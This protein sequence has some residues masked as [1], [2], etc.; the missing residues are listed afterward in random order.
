M[1]K[2]ILILVLLLLTG[3]GAI[4]TTPTILTPNEFPPPPPMTPIVE[5]PQVTATA[6]IEPRMQPILPSDLQEAETFFLIVKT[7]MAAGDDTG[8]AKRVKYPLQVNLNGQQIFIHNEAEFV[9]QYETIFDAKF[10]QVLSDIDESTLTLLSNGVQVGNG[11][12]WFNY[13]CVD[14]E[15]SDA[16]FLITQINK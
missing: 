1:M 10:V 9:K 8:V 12:L 2:Q 11:I 13:F 6:T 5:W 3:C 7:S 15:C 4:P 14:L 16:Q